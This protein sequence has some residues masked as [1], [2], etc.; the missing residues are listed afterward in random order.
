MKN[1]YKSYDNIRQSFDMTYVKEIL[2]GFNTIQ[3]QIANQVLAC[4][5]MNKIK[6]FEA[7]VTTLSGFYNLVFTI[8]FSIINK[9]GI[10]KAF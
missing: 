8:T 2:V 4:E 10:Y 3:L 5:D 1:I 6:Q 7:R 9:N